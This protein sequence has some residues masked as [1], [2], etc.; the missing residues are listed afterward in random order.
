MTRLHALVVAA[1]VCGIVVPASA[2]QI[3]VAFA[4]GSL[5][6]SGNSFN[7]LG[8]VPGQGGGTFV[9]FNG[10]VLFRGNLGVQGEVNWRASQ[11]MYGGQVPYR[12]L[13]GTSM[14]YMRGASVSVSGL[15]PLG[16]S[17]AK[18][19]GSTQVSITVTTTETA[20]ITSAVTIS[21]RM[22]VEEF[23]FTSGGMLL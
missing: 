5:F 10:D 6:S 22:L 11:T 8:F 9:G 20:R 14:Q 21:W 16:E 3:D 19:S 17:E 18:A 2:Q 15:K 7:S 12:P 13:F 23:A 1:L 4:G